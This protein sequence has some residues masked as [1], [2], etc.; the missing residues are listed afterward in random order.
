MREIM[1]ISAESHRDNAMTSV[2]VDVQNA[3]RNWAST[4]SDG[5]LVWKIADEFRELWH[6]WGMALCLPEWQVPKLVIY[7]LDD[8]AE[9]TN[10]VVAG[11]VKRAKKTIFAYSE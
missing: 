6:D 11:S 1:F 5:A 10:D 4:S 3:A 2:L 8:I 9:N 7:T